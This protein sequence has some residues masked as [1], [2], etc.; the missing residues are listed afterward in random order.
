MNTIATN[1]MNELQ[2]KNNRKSDEKRIAFME[3]LV[4]KAIAGDGDALHDLCDN[5]G[6]SILFRAKYILGSKMNEMD[7]EDVSQEVLLR[8]CEK[9]Q[10][11][12]EPK[13]FKVWLNRII[14]NESKRYALMKI[15]KG[16]DLDIENHREEILEKSTDVLPHE[17]VINKELRE[18][19]MDIIADLPERQRQVIV[20]YYY[21][22]LSVTEIAETM[23]VTHQTVSQ[24]L[25]MARKKIKATIDK[26][27]SS[28]YM[29]VA[30]ILPID[31]ALSEIISVEATNFMPQ[32]ADWLQVA[33]DACQQYFSSGAVAAAA[34]TVTA[35]TAVTGA[36]GAA[37]AT[38]ATAAI[39]T[40][41]IVAAVCSAVAVAA[42]ALSV[43]IPGFSQPNR[44]EMSGD[45]VF[46]GGTSHGE[47]YISINPEYAEP[48][49]NLE[50][51]VLEWWIETDGDGYV[52]YE[53]TGSEGV[54]DAL[55]S[56]QESGEDGLYHIV[57]RLENEFGAI[58][59]LGGNFRIRTEDP[60]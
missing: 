37:A 21:E 29:S 28:A 3:S 49:T 45:V 51:I 2:N 18:H 42:V 36:T 47:S 17:Y 46:S 19:I 25:V 30:S 53:N 39:S 26:E 24:Y 54:R 32:N 50:I 11:L 58:Y 16:D 31:M 13:A 10:D 44:A 35:T 14:T 6:K 59:R 9:I 8:V 23:N 33:L 7:A 20:F 57:F 4:E 27:Q 43:V 41:G 1:K 22:E 15:E 55:R 5:L 12:R 56:L 40:A 38:T 48:Q 34:T 52:L 60:G